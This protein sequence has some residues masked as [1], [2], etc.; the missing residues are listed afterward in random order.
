MTNPKGTKG[1][2]NPESDT[3]NQEEDKPR[4]Y[5]TGRRGAGVKINEIS[6]DLLSAFLVSL[7]PL[8]GR[9]PIGKLIF[10]VQAKWYGLQS[11]IRP[12]GAGV[13]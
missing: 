4:R 10:L 13:R 6:F 5:S 2:K 1:T 3:R 8:Y 9:L 12:H 7:V 11:Y